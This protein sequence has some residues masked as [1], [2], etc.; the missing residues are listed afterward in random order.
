MRRWVSWPLAV[1]VA[2]VVVGPPFALYRAQKALTKVAR[3]HGTRTA[4]LAAQLWTQLKRPPAWIGRQRLARWHAA[5]TS[6]FDLLGERGQ[7]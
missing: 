6:L 5:A 2:G 1:V 3:T 7:G 4:Q